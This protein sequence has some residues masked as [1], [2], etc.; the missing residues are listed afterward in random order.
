M[1]SQIAKRSILLAGQKTSISLEEAFWSR[2]KEIA[3]RRNLR[4]S[5]LVQEVNLQRQHTNLSSAIR[6]F[7]LE[8]CCAR[9]QA[10]LG[11][12]HAAETDETT[13]DRVNGANASN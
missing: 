12:G 3:E 2:L 4:V 6:V 9:L 5:Q 13:S 1:H 11:N 7:V 8:D 10:S